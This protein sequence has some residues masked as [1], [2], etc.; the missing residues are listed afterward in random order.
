MKATCIKTDPLQTLEV[1]KEYEI[2][3]HENK[4]I[5]KWAGMVISKEVFN[6]HFEEKGGQD[7]TAK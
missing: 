3:Q 7:E 2:E 1:G 6:E 5:V 4:F